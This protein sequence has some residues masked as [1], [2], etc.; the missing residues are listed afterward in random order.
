MKGF[1][2]IELMVVMAIIAVL[3]G[4][5]V[6]GI[7]A[8]LTSSRDTERR[9]AL[10]D[11]SLMITKYLTEQGSLPSTVNATV[12]R[13]GVNVGNNASYFVKLSGGAKL[14]A[15]AS[16]TA[17]DSTGSVYCFAAGTS[18]SYSLEVDLEGS[19]TAATGGGTAC[20]FATN[21]I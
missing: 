2:L 4:L 6:F 7:N 10:Q 21:K 5:G 13:D 8:V 18:G 15:S 9:S 16:A 17:S 14:M 12:A 3:T 1:T 11:V 20:N 19:G